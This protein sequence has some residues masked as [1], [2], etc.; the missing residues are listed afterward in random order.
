MLLQELHDSTH[1]SLA[2][3]GAL[4][5]RFASNGAR[6]ARVTTHQALRARVSSLPLSPPLRFIHRS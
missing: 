6:A 2:E 4:R 3:L 1:F 5:E